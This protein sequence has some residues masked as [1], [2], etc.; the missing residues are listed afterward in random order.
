MFISLRLLTGNGL[1]SAAM[2]FT[3]AAVSG[4]NGLSCWPLCSGSAQT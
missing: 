1:L 4:H 3:I 2:A